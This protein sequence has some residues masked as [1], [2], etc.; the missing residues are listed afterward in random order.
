MLPKFSL[1]SSSDEG[2]THLCTPETLDQLWYEAETLGDVE[3]DKSV[4]SK[5]YSATIA[6][7]RKS[8]TRI[9]AVGKDVEIKSALAKAINEARGLGA[10]QQ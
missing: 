9:R 5:E 2:I 8:G 10:G 4:F 7:S 1:R 3:V 6:W